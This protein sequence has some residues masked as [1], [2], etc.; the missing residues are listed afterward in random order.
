MPKNNNKIQQPWTWT[1]LLA[2][3]DQENE[4]TAQYRVPKPNSFDSEGET[5]LTYAAKSGCHS[6]IDNMFEANHYITPENK[7]DLL[8][9]CN[10]NGLSPLAMAAT[11]SDIGSVKSLLNQIEDSTEIK[12]I[13]NQSLDLASYK[14]HIKEAKKQTGQPCEEEND[15]MNHYFINGVTA[16][17]IT[18]ATIISIN[19][20]LEKNTD[21]DRE[22]EQQ[23]LKDLHNVQFYLKQKGAERQ[24]TL[25]NS[26][27][28][29]MTE[30]FRANQQRAITPITTQQVGFFS[31]SNNSKNKKDRDVRPRL[32]TDPETAAEVP[33]HHTEDPEETT[34]PQPNQR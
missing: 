12:E 33:Y 27:Q 3:N 5:A 19:L 31:G 15:L 30:S 32:E 13:L 23:R 9:T 10:S 2:K 16:L 24:V 26:L 17:D 28:R 7:M 4:A 14:D 21:I 1:P 29:Y 18:D 20:K 25:P 34:S 6:L 11:L 8:Q 22:Y